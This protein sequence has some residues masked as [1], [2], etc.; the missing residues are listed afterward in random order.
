MLVLSLASG[1]VA[2][3]LQCEVGSRPVISISRFQLLLPCSLVFSS[4][5]SLS[6]IMMNANQ[7]VMYAWVEENVITLLPRINVS[8]MK[9]T[10]WMESHV[11]VQFQ[12]FQPEKNICEL[13]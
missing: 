13:Q 12:L 1:T 3:L 2:F 10:W 4:N 7:E 5:L 8:V 9:A 11:Q 6:Q